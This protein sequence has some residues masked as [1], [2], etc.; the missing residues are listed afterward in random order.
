[1]LE[2][3]HFRA[4]IVFRLPA[5]VTNM[6]RS[7]RQFLTTIATGTAVLTLPRRLSARLGDD[8]KKTHILLLEGPLLGQGRKGLRLE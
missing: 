6:N 4:W 3:R 2:W 1:M 7:R 8:K 5:G